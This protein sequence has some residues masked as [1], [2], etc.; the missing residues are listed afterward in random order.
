MNTALPDLASDQVPSSLVV[1]LTRMGERVAAL[2]ARATSEIAALKKDTEII[3][4]AIHDINNNQQRIFAAEQ[5]CANGLATLVEKMTSHAEQIASIAKSI[6]E[7]GALRV[8]AE[9]AWWAA[10]KIALV[11]STTLG[12]IAASVTV[13]WWALQHVSVH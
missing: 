10:G 7:F 4:T 6:H 12:T 5:Q 1:P 2:E 11:L 9:G 3:R 8:H 13:M